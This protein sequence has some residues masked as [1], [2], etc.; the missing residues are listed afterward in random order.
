L[1]QFEEQYREALQQKRQEAVATAAIE[2]LT[3]DSILHRR[4][5]KTLLRT[6][7]ETDRQKQS[8]KTD[9]PGRTESNQ[10]QA[11]SPPSATV[12]SVISQ[13][14]KKNIVTPNGNAMN[15]SPA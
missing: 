13:I 11:R 2:A 15:N 4:D 8:K 3:K 12:I 9:D 6:H 7:K 1:Q 10:P 14:E 5:V